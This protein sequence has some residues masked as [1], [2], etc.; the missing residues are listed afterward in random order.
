MSHRQDRGHTP[1]DVS[2]LQTPRRRPPQEGSRAD[3]TPGEEGCCTSWPGTSTLSEAPLWL[4][5]NWRKGGWHLVGE[6]GV[7]PR[8]CDTAITTINA[9]SPIIRKFLRSCSHCDFSTNLTNHL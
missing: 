2:R 5:R 6:K 3:L 1:R 4:C 7:A 8:S 9:N